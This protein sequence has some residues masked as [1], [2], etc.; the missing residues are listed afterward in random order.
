MRCEF[1]CL[2]SNSYLIWGSV[3][4]QMPVGVLLQQIIGAIQNDV[5]ENNIISHLH[6]N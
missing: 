4:G 2:A 1:A 5:D 3:L 6:L